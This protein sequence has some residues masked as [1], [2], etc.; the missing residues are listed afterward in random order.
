PDGRLLALIEGNHVSLRDLR[1]SPDREELAFRE[2]MARPDPF[3]HQEQAER[4][5]RERQWFAAAFH[6][7]QALQSRPDAALY[8]RRGHALAEQGPREGA[9]ADYARAVQSG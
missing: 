6:L 1:A 5:E 3:W 4:C 9:R 2:A 7:G 8:R